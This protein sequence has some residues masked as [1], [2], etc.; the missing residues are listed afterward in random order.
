MRMIN[1]SFF[2]KVLHD[3]S[4]QTMYFLAIGGMMLLLGMG[5]LTVD[6]GHAYVVR[7][8]LQG[9]VN[10]AALAGVSGLSNG[11]AAQTASNF[12]ANNNVQ[13][14]GT[15]TSPTPT[16]FCAKM[17]MPAG[18]S[19]TSSSL[20]ANAVQ[21]SA[22]ATLPT[23]FMKM[24]GVK[25][26][27]VNATAT[28]SPGEVKP[29][30]VEFVLDTTPSMVDADSNCTGASTAEQ[31]AL[32][33]IQG[34]LAKSNPCSTGMTSCTDAQSNVRVGLMTFPNIK[35]TDAPDNY[36][37]NGTVA[38]QLY[39]SPVIPASTSTA[40]YTPITYTTTGSGAKT[41]TLTYQSTYGAKDMDTNGFYTNFYSSSS[42]SG[43][44]DT[45]TL[46]KA[47]GDNANNKTPCLQLPNTNG[48]S[49]TSGVTSF[50]GAIYAAQT[51]LQAE[52]SVYPTVNGVPTRT[53][54][55]FLSDG[56]ANSQS[57]LF[58]SATNTTVSSNG[59]LALNSN[60]KYPSGIDACQQ[61]IT[62]AQYVTNAGTRV[63]AVAYG[64]EVGGCLYNTNGSASPAPNGTKNGSGSGSDVTPI[65]LAG[66]LNV[67]I[68][69]ITQMIPCMT[70]KNMASS[71]SYFYSDA[72]EETGKG[73]GV[74]GVDATCTSPDHSDVTSLNSIFQG[75]Y[76]SLS[77]ARL[78]PNSA[79]SSN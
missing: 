6:V 1:L 36:N 77:T 18:E 5:G 69:S 57:D 71:L 19:C 67:P 31:C 64:S 56:Q 28:A 32:N 2:R 14:L 26:L 27:T 37:C 15:I 25:T 53:A 29:W 58:P 45:S 74:N 9:A 21:I 54:I 38:F 23:Y 41:L 13:G 52:Q 78:I 22:T 63:Y 20:P 48:Y 35:T 40:S 12:L 61:A 33:G 76:G 68:T 59:L 17:M 43:L 75:I 49:G 55:I 4:G 24:L 11:Q 42:S 47:I 79:N 72:N 10:A 3:E 8:Q 51:A 30:I 73:S 62:A 50:A 44:N 7:T 16:V 70:M 34:M 39:S 60:G 65:I 66:N 46:V